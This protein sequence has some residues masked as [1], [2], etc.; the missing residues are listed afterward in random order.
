M[1]RDARQ[2][3]IR[4]EC[5]PKVLAVIAFCYESLRLQ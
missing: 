2:L 5:L 1:V 4:C 3:A